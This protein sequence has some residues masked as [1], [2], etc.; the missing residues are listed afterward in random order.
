MNERWLGIQEQ[1]FRE[2]GQQAAAG[3]NRKQP[4][5][6]VVAFGRSKQNIVERV[7]G[8]ANYLVIDTSLA[9]AIVDGAK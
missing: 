4:G 8:M 1:D 7:V 9:E 5:V 6:I 2:C 3:D